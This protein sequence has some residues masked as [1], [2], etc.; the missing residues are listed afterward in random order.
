MSSPAERET[1]RAYRVRYRSQ[2]PDYVERAR[3]RQRTAQKAAAS[4]AYRQRVKQRPKCEGCG[5]TML[6]PHETG[7]CGFCLE[8]R[9]LG[10]RS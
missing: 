2:H 8:E 1:E 10:V 6:E 4:R 9:A 5:W 7:L 3:E